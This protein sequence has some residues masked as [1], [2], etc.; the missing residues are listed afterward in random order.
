MAGINK[1]I[2]IGRL[3]NDPDVKN[4][5]PS[6]EHRQNVAT[7]ESW[8]DKQTGERREQTEWHSIIAYRQ[9]AEIMRQYLKKGSQVYTRKVSLPQ[10]A[11][12][13]RTRP[14]HNGNYYRPNANAKQY[15]SPHGTHQ[16]AV[17]QYHKPLKTGTGLTDQ[18]RADSR[19]EQF[20]DAS[21]SILTKR[22]S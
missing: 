14:L 13:K 15:K 7:S 10:M 22:L 1:V 4:S 5:F 12:P 16:S 8:T 18:E 21:F 2:I 19:A 9:T 6:H 11:R 3:G 17:F 20:D